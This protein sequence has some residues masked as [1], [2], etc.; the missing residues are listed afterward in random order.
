MGSGMGG[1]EFVCRKMSGAIELVS[2]GKVE[3][4]GGRGQVGQCVKALG[5]VV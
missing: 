1:R 2:K 4:G 3:S 5:M